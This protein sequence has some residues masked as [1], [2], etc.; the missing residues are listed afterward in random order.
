M[1]DES[2]EIELLEQN[3]NKTR[4][5]S[6]RMINILDSFD[7]RL[8]KLEKS[9]LPLYNS[10]Q[11]LQRRAN[12]IEKALL[13]IDEVASNHEGIEAE[14]ALILRGPQPGQIDA[15][16]D[17]LE[18]LNASIAFKGSDPDSLET[19]RLVETGAK[20]LTQL[21]T[22]VVAEGSTGSIPP[23]GEELTMCPFPAVSLSTLRNL[24]TFLRTLPLPST[25]PSHAAAPGIL[26]TLKE[27]QKGYADMRGTWARK[28][29]ETQGKR[30]LDRADTIDAIVVG[31]DFG[32][33]AESLISVAETE[34]EL[35]VDL[36]PLTGPTMTAS[37]FDTL[38]NPILV[39]FSTIV[40]SLVGSIKRSLQ[41]FAFLALSSFESLSVLQ[42]R[43]EKLLTLRGNESRKD[44]NE[45]K[46]GLHALRAVCLRSFPEF[47]AD[48]KMASMG[49][50]RA[51]Q[52][53]GPADFT[54]Q[55]VRY[56]DRLPEVRDAAASILLVV[57]DGNWKMGQGTQV[58]K[59][60]K[61]GDGDER[62][63]LEHY[64]YDVVMTALSSLMTVSKTPRRS[65]AL[66][67]IFLL[68]NVSYLRQ[69][70]LVEPRLRSLPDLLSSPTR[71]VLNSNYRTAKANYFDANFSPLMQVL[72]D[73]PK[74]KSGKTATKE[75]FIRFFDLFEEVLERHKMARVLEDDPAGREAL[76]EEVIK[77]ILKNVSG[78]VYIIIHRLI[79]SPDIKMSPETV[80][81]QLRALYRSGD[82][83]L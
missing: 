27:A 73:D 8:A 22:K 24:V 60:A 26:S 7:T 5:I 39:L 65:P 53:T 40:T 61:L 11:I 42:P 54:I 32:K 79:K 57:G 56:M 14:E 82:D 2:A 67:A 18:R 51:E 64:A 77:L 31:K 34:Y 45:F 35:L 49:N 69:H 36:I 71:D 15:Y 29:L 72:S 1:D 78:V 76:G 25:H 68:N 50:T 47:L 81:T 16:R 13:K 46:E 75:K 41:K 4:H 70:I 6:N 48:L 66:N 9:I 52:S 62:V 83:R 58:G 37:T 17:A 59:G 19:A 55:T 21:Y 80:T 43:W 10:T 33:W 38:L 23:P 28:C 3:I 12:N 74:D 30:V 20:K 44:T 63:I